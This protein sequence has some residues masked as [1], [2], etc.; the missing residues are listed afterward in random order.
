MNNVKRM[1]AVIL[2]GFATQVVVA[3]D[4]R[5]SEVPTAIL[6]KFQKDYPKAYDIEWELDGLNYKVEF[7]LGLVSKD[8]KVW[9]D[10]T[11]KVLRKKEEL[12]VSDLPKSV[13]TKVNEKYPS[14]EGYR[15]DDIDKITEGKDIVYVVEVKGV[16]TWKAVFDQNGTFLNQTPD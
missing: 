10:A 6:T 5:Q 4:I 3:Q 8:Y 12:S 11:G 13:L 16:R 1:I 15:L 7:E 14:S 2:I 9:Y